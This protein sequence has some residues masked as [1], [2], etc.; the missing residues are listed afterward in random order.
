MRASSSVGARPNRKAGGRGVPWKRG[1][2]ASADLQ[3]GREPRAARPTPLGCRAAEAR[4]QLPGPADIARSLRVGFCPASCVLGVP[5]AGGVWRVCVSRTRRMPPGEQGSEGAGVVGVPLPSGVWW[6]CV[7]R[8]RRMPP[9][10][11][12]RGRRRGG[13]A[14]RQRRVAGSGASHPQ[15]AAR[16]HGS[17]GA[18]VLGV[19][20]AA[21]CGGFGCLAPAGCRRGA[22]EQ[23][24]GGA[25]VQACR[26]PAACGGFG[27]LAPAACRQ[28]A[29][30][31]GHWL[32]AR[33][34]ARGVRRTSADRARRSV[35]GPRRPGSR[36]PR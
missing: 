26:S 22:G 17:Q 9:G 36:C 19:P 1:G 10:A 12:E 15:D 8:T 18:G 16:E 31:S 27:C 2:R 28:G 7:S 33:A 24:S 6:V 4:E 35:R 20:L 21:A 32:S 11:G 34:A 30:W 13:R 23:G 5:L 3:T 29:G 25:G 14:A